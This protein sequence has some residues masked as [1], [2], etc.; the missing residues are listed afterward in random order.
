MMRRG[1][2]RRVAA[3]MQALPAGGVM[4]AVEA[5]E[6]ETTPLFDGAV[7]LAAVNGATSVVVSGERA[8]VER[9]VAHFEGV[10]RRVK[11]LRVSHA[12]HSPLMEPML[13]DFAA[14]VSGLS[15]AEPLLP[16]VSTVTGKPVEEGLLTDPAYWVRHVRD[17]VRFHDAIT[18][19][20]ELGVSWRWA[21]VGCWSRRPSRFWRTPVGRGR[22][23]SR[24]CVR[25]RTSPAPR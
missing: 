15:F 16:M 24:P 2:W 4:A 10:G 23:S 21:R 13:E 22:S 7:G 9:V 8:A 18:H 20:G 14:V 11:W 19:L 5:S 25:V 12:F 6:D 3:L 1:W 17:T